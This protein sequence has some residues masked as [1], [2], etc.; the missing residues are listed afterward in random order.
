MNTISEIKNPSIILKEKIDK[1]DYDEIKKLEKL[2]AERDDVSFKLELEY[3][4][5][6]R[7]ASGRWTGSINDIMFYDGSDLKG[8]IGISDFG[9]NALE[10]NGMVH[11]DY[12]NMGIFSKLFS[13]A[14]DE[15]RKRKQPEMLL[16]S[17]GSSASGIGFIKKACDEYDHSEYDMVLNMGAEQKSGPRSNKLRRASRGDYAEIARQDKIYFGPGQDDDTQAFEQKYN[18]NNGSFTYMAETGDKVT[19]KVRIEINEGAGGI[20]GLGVLPEYR[21]RGFGREILTMAIEKLKEM[22]AHKIV[23]QVEINNK[24]AL[25]LYKSC[26]FEVNYVMDYYKINK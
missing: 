7:K 14:E 2:C 15:W 18:E 20:Y 10:V 17:D 3:K 4:L 19:G 1:K 12:R 23:L 22:G 24:N 5:S 13:L 21:G 25:N 8:Y 9:G 16:L 6:S 26:G 11:P